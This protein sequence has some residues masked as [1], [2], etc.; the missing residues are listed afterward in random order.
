MCLPE[1]CQDKLDVTGVGVGGSGGVASERVKS[2]RMQ[3]VGHL[4]AMEAVDE[5]A[6]RA[7]EWIESEIQRWRAEDKAFRE[8]WNKKSKIEKMTIDDEWKKHV[9]PPKNNGRRSKPKI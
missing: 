1:L 8:E 4:I 2:V 3:N 9:G 6:D 5:T 7:A